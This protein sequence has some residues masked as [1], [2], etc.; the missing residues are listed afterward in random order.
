MKKENVPNFHRDVGLLLL[1]IGVSSAFA[2]LIAMRQT[3]DRDTFLIYPKHFL[4]LGMLCCCT[5]FVL[6]GAIVRPA[7]TVAVVLWIAA[8]GVGLDAGENWFALPVRDCEFAFV[9]AALAFTGPG[10]FSVEHWRTLGSTTDD[11]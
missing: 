4:I 9:F 7:S 11:T 8:A 2:F 3:A 5:F 6:C 1:R 10:R